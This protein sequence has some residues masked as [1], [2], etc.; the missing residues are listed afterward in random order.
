MVAVTRRK[1]TIDEY[2]RLVD[3]GFFTEN[4]RLVDITI[5]RTAFRLIIYI[6]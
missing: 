2:H 1:F 3:L 6:N 4:D 5:R